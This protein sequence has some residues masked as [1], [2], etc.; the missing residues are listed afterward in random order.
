MYL[1]SVFETLF[2]EALRAD[3]AELGKIDNKDIHRIIICNAGK[4]CSLPFLCIYSQSQAQL[5]L[6]E[7]HPWFH[8][9]EEL[10]KR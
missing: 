10:K 7:L 8:K 9:K 5:V 4:N 1:I 6:N 2:A 3:S